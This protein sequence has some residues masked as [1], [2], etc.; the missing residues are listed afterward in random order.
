MKESEVQKQLI[1]R[2][3]DRGWKVYRPPAPSSVASR[4]QMKRTGSNGWPD[5]FA[6]RHSEAIAI[7]VKGS[8]G[9]LSDTQSEW[10]EALYDAGVWTHVCTPENV[11]ELCTDLR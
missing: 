6:V 1:D 7:E 9:K 3:L 11:D 4:A 2:L 10:L 8:R 5:I